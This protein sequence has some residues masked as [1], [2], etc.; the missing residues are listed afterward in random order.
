LVAYSASNL[1]GFAL[2]Y[3]WINGRGTPAPITSIPEGL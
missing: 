1:T 3:D 2:Q